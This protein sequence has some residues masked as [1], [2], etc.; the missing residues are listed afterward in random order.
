ML[1]LFLQLHTIPYFKI[2][3]ISFHTNFNNLKFKQN[4]Y[5]L[6]IA[7]TPGQLA[8]ITLKKYKSRKK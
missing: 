5:S 8:Y 7:T 3:L 4:V 6:F 2:L 1:H